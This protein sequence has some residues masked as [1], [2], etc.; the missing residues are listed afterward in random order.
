VVGAI[1]GARDK[2]NLLDSMLAEFFEHLGFHGSFV[3]ILGNDQRHHA[4]E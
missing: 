2:Q 1:G 4:S 3:R